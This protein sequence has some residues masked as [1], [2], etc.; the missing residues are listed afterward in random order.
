[1]D[2]KTPSGLLIRIELHMFAHTH[3]QTITK[4]F[5]TIWRNVK[6]SHTHTSECKTQDGNP[7]KCKDVTHIS[8][9]KTL[10]NNP[11]YAKK[12]SHDVMR[13]LPHT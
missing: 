5:T 1:M 4:P 7:K 11:K 9:H 13:W 12:L 8:K 3:T 10:N 2:N 6:M